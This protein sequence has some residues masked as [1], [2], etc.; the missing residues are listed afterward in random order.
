LVGAWLE[1]IPVLA[2]LAA[3]S[4]LADTAASV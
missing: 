3:T 4:V 2:V 1:V